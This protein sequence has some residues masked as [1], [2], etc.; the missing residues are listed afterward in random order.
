[1]SSLFCMS[2]SIC[3][4]SQSCTAH[5]T[6]QS[7]LGNICI[8]TSL[9]DNNTSSQTDSIK[10]AFLIAQLTD[11]APKCVS[12]LRYDNT[13][14]IQNTLTLNE[15]QWSPSIMDTTGTKHFVVYSEVFF[16]QGGDCWPRP[17]CNPGQLCWSKNVDHEISYIGKRSLEF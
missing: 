12:I 11:I 15:L 6:P 4:S 9:L 5:E 3:R 14:C 10:S 13:T 16:A 2:L 1:M 8:L 7:K 17:S